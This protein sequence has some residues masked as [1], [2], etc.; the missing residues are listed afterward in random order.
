M[1]PRD[2]DAKV[3]LMEVFM[4]GIGKELPA[5]LQELPAKQ[6]AGH[7]ETIIEHYGRLK[8]E[9]SDLLKRL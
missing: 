6:L 8:A 7:W 2:W 3:K 1:D 4:E 5:D 9:I